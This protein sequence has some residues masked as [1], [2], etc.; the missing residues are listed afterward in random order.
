MNFSIISNQIGSGYLG[1]V[2]QI[3][4]NEPPYH[5]LIA[6]IFEEKAREQ[7]LKEREILSILSNSTEPFNECIIKLK[8]LN[9]SLDFTSHFAYNSQ[10]IIFDYLEHGNLSKYFVYLDTLPDISEKYIKLICFKLLKAL[11][12]IHKNNIYHNKIDINNIMFDNE[13]NPIIIHF[14]ESYRIDNSNYRKDFEEL[15]KLFGKLMT[16]GKFMNFKYNKKLKYYE[17]TD[18][19]KRKIREK[20][21]WDMF[22]NIPKEF[23][24]FF[25]LLVKSKDVNIDELFNHIWLKEIKYKDNNYINI[26]N[27][28]KED[29][30]ERYRKLLDLDEM[31][32]N[33]DNNNINSIINMENN[34]NNNSLT[35]NLNMDR[36]IECENEDKTIF[37]L[38]IKKINNEPKGILFDYIQIIFNSNIN[39]DYNISNIIYNYIFEL[40]SSIKDI[41]KNINIKIDYPDNFLS[42]NAI[43][44][45]NKNNEINEINN[46][47]EDINNI[48]NCEEDDINYDENDNDNDNDN[49]NEDLMINIK[50]VKYSPENIYEYDINKE[51]YYLIFNY[52]QG[53]I[54]DYYYYLKIIKEKAKSLLNINK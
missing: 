40:Q 19:Q 51:K 37:T 9:I 43:F 15:G 28:L 25:N 50:L 16:S 5:T 30:K 20:K 48:D 13:F 34:Y 53:E 27:N 1:K 26:E 31:K 24:D 39:H 46:K 23:I 7:F 4:G 35:Q 11:K 2:Y 14:S 38:E 44:E 33:I 12:I 18:N 36:S 17:I 32:I 21:F 42:F 3:R 22:K 45:E 6:K 29:F 49:D 52:I 10:Y 41:D 8:N 54:C 47:E